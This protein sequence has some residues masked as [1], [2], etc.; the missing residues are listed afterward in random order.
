[1]RGVS[2]ELQSLTGPHELSG[3]EY[4]RIEQSNGWGGTEYCDVLY[5]ILDDVA[6]EAVEDPCDGYRSGLEG[7]Y[8]SKHVVANT[9][10]PVAVVGIHRTKGEYGGEDD[11]IE[12]HDAATGALVLE[13]GTRNIDDYYPSFVG[14]FYPEAMAVNKEVSE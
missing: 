7:I 4:G 5:L 11:V 2:V 10:G 14:F 13:V 9:F 6:L 8:P 12:L 3:T 1:M